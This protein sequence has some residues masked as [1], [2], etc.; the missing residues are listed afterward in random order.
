M[1]DNTIL[2]FVPMRSGS[3]G[4]PNK[5]MKEINGKPLCY[6]MLSA[7]A[8][9]FVDRI[10]VS[11]DSQAYTTYIKDEFK[12]RAEVVFRSVEVSSDTASTESVVLEYLD[13]NKVEEEYLLLAQVT[14]PLVDKDQVNRFIDHLL[15]GKN[16]LLSVVNL[17]ERFFWDSQGRPLNYNPLQRPRRQDFHKKLKYEIP[18]SFFVENGMFYGKLVS[19]WIENKNRLIVPSNLFEM[20]IETLTEI[21][22]QDD[23]N[24][25]ERLLKVRYNNE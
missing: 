2:A 6:W 5:N 19:S 14:S 1:R 3:K 10:V 7:L 8:N 4:I 15:L 11:T 22:S 23:W 20:P 13:N 17:S 24:F 18:H 16:S 21:D 25:V 9:S 12:G